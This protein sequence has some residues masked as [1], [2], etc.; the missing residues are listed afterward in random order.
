MAGG[1]HAC[2]IL[3]AYLAVYVGHEVMDT[4]L[5]RT[6]LPRLPCVSRPLEYDHVHLKS[7]ELLDHLAA[8]PLLLT[9]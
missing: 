1:K 9:T 2:Q 6:S 7:E 8:L 4:C 3:L 5:G